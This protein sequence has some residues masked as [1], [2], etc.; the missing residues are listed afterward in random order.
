[1]Y[2]KK[3]T[4]YCKYELVKTPNNMQPYQYKQRVDKEN[5]NY[6]NEIIR[7]GG[8]RRISPYCKNTTSQMIEKKRVDFLNYASENSKPILKKFH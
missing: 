7:C 4:N 6:N 3:Y 2:E 8:D 1:M 5:K